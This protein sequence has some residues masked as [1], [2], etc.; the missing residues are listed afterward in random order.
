[1]D[2]L[3]AP[4]LTFHNGAPIDADTVVSLFAKLSSLELYEKELAHV[5]N[6]TAPNPLKVV[7]TLSKPDLGFAGLFLA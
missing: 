2:L 6:I 7:F 4:G 3:P 1:M 5:D